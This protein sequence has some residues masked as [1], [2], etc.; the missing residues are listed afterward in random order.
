M[1]S[2]SNISHIDAPESE[3]IQV[4]PTLKEGA[5]YFRQ[6]RFAF[7][8]LRVIQCVTATVILF[9]P[10]TAFR[11]TAISNRYELLRGNPNLLI[12]FGFNLGIAS[13]AL[14][15]NLICYV[16]Y[17]IDQA[18][19]PFFIYAAIVDFVASNAFLGLLLTSIIRGGLG[20][21]VVYQVLCVLAW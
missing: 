18:R 6:C 12:N 20:T 9:F 15:H 17:S 5:Q 8:I 14:L 7:L 11:T 4:N 10:R 16:V 3:D 1:E 21:G 13:G 2:P 19:L